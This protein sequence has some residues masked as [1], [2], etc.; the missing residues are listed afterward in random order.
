MRIARTSPRYYIGVDLGQ[1]RDYTAI[2]IIEHAPDTFQE[3]DPVTFAHLTRVRAGL[4]HAERIPLDTPYPDVV[5]RVSNIAQSA[6]LNGPITL[7]VDSTGLGAPVVD[8]LRRS[9]LNCK[10]D[11]IVFTEQR[12]QDLIANL[13]FLFEGQS[14]T[15]AHNLPLLDAVIEELTGLRAKGTVA[16]HDDLAFALA[17]AAWPLRVRT[18]GGLQPHPLPIYFQKDPIKWPKVA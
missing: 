17:L 7:L 4:R 1:T 11:P 2:V 12:K 15:L 8:H 3:R 13:I 14:L 16:K 10:L 5:F 6:N 18:P 9:K